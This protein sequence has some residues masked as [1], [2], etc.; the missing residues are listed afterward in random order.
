MQG[1]DYGNARLRAMK[2]RL[3]SAPD[4]HQLAASDSLDQLAAFL[5]RTPYRES[6]EAALAQ[7][8]GLTAL[9]QGIKQNVVQTMRKIRSF[10]QGHEGSLIGLILRR[11]DIHNLK[12]ILRGLANRAAPAEIDAAFL[13]VGDIPESVLMELARAPDQNAA[14]DL[15]ATLREPTASP[16]LDLRFRPADSSDTSQMEIALDRWHF[17]GLETFI[18]SARLKGSLFEEAC[19]LEADF[20]NLLT[21]FRLIPS[22]DGTGGLPGEEVAALPDWFV[23]SGRLPL[24]MLTQAARQTSLS[25]AVRRLTVAVYEEPLRTGLESASRTGRVSDLERHLSRYRLR[26]LASL[27]GKDPLGPGVALAYIGLKVSEIN[28]LRWVAHGIDIGL[29]PALIQEELEFAA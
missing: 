12:A 15:L 8:T 17:D 29:T 27:P 20:L 4:L 3:L 16:L 11:F 24:T 6:L 2:S 14:I 10:F 28:N 5:T 23:G 22:A 21:V 1:Y 19:K 7:A 13:P 25:G 26:W 9:S 18:A